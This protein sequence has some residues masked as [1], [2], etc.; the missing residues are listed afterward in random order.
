MWYKG[1]YRQPNECVFIKYIKVNKSQSYHNSQCF[2]YNLK[3]FDQMKA[4][5][6]HTLLKKTIGHKALSKE[7]WTPLKGT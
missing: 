4:N 7:C 5:I 1:E 6:K 2:K 3:S